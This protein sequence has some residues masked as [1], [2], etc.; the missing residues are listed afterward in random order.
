MFVAVLSL[1][2][3]ILFSSSSTEYV[4]PTGASARFAGA[5]ILVARQERD[6][7]IE[8]EAALLKL[9]EDL[10]H[11]RHFDRRCGGHRCCGVVADM[12][13]GREVHHFDCARCRKMKNEPMKI[14]SQRLHR[15]G[16]NRRARGRKNPQERHQYPSD[17][18]NDISYQ[19][20]NRPRCSQY[21]TGCKHFF[22]S[23]DEY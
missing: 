21:I 10:Y 3:I 23:R 20:A 4:L 2:S 19:P 6:V 13:A 9:A 17:N 15:W 16:N 11:H 12:I 22:A 8:V 7:T 5:V 18:G 14:G 1:T